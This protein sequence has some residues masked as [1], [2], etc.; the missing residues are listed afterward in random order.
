MS[1][2]RNLDALVASVQTAFEAIHQRVFRGDPAANPR[3][4]VEVV[5]PAF[6]EDVPTLILI[7]P[8]TLNG[9]AFPPD[10]MFPE[11]LQVGGKQYPVYPHCL[12]ELGPYQSVNLLSDV[13][14][15]Q[16]PGSARA[17]ARSLGEPFREAVASACRERTV[18]DPGRRD[19]LRGRIGGEA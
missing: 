16:S 3:L 18:P 13:H 19:L 6:V 15:L 2:D 9:M 12:D 5:E 17:V 8:W 1:G 11:A 14:E 10:G 7:T 4:K